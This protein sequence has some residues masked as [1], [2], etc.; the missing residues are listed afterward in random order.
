MMRNSV[1][2][3]HGSSCVVHHTLCLLIF[4]FSYHYSFS[5]SATIYGTVKDSVNKPFS[6]V[7][8][9]VY[10]KPIGT[11]TDEKGSYKL[12]VPANEQ[13]KIIFSFTGF[14]RDSIIIELKENEKKEINKQLKGK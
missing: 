3:I 10:G 6:E 4:L 8:V 14:S 13:L 2:T 11:L 9:S 7:S 12:T 1:F 5:Q